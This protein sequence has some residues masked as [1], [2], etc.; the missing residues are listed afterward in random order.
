ML[1]FKKEYAQFINS[2]NAANLLMYLRLS[3]AKRNNLIRLEKTI[4]FLEKSNDDSIDRLEPIL[5]LQSKFFDVLDDLYDMRPASHKNNGFSFN[6][7]FDDLSELENN[8]KQAIG[9]YSIGFSI[10]F[11]FMLIHWAGLVKSLGRKVMGYGQSYP[12]A[13]KKNDDRIN[14]ILEC[15][16]SI[17]IVGN[18]YSTGEKNIVA[19]DLERNID[20]IFEY[21][22]ADRYHL[23]DP[24]F[25]DGLYL[26]ITPNRI[27][28]VIESKNNNI[29]NIIMILVQVEACFDCL[30]LNLRHLWEDLRTGGHLCLSSFKTRNIRPFINIFSRFPENVSY[31]EK[32]YA[33]LYSLKRHSS[34]YLSESLKFLLYKNDQLLIDAKGI[35][36]QRCPNEI[37]IFIIKW[38]LLLDLLYDNWRNNKAKLAHVDENSLN[39]SFLELSPGLTWPFTD[40]ALNE[41]ITALEKYE[42]TKNK[43]RTFAQMMNAL[44]KCEFERRYEDAL[45]EKWMISA[46][47]ENKKQKVFSM[48]GI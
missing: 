8:L 9:F 31:D 34:E 15:L 13:Y 16:Q 20:N 27:K 40:E 22:G 11:T 17:A 26:V 14:V 28:Y 33:T 39:D 2:Q 44:I 4:E 6:R 23:K 18:P 41:I 45:I 37:K 32:L 47:E 38:Y 5:H 30:L 10:N 12:T 3:V 1:K 29:E 7:D 35:I 48:I 43:K 46:I 19:I 24:D 42:T 25:N 36:H 21:F